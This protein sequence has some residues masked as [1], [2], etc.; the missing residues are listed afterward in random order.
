[1][2]EIKLDEEQHNVNDLQEAEK[3]RDGEID[4]KS[5]MTKVVQ[6]EHWGNVLD[7]LDIGIMNRKGINKHCVSQNNRRNGHGVD[8][9]ECACDVQ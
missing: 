5:S 1:M 7:E 8:G 4:H 3:N 6:C 2:T 9:V